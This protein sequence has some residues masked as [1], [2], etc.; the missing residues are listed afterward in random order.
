VNSSILIALTSHLWQSTLFALA[1]GSL[2]LLVRKNSARVRYCMWLAA[3]AKF[4]V[5]FAALTAV[6]ARIPWPLAVHGMGPSMATL[7]SQFGL[8]G[9]RAPAAHADLSG[10]FLPALGVF[11]LLGAIAVVARSFAGWMRI[12]HALRDSTHASLAFVIPV[13]SSAVQLEPAVVGILRPVLLLPR[14]IEQRLTPEQ[15]LTVLAHERCHVVWRDNLAAALHMLVEALFWFHPLIWWLGKRLVDERER[16]CDERVLADGHP[17]ENYAEGIL[18]VCEHYL[19]SRLACAAGVAGANLRQRIEAIMNNRLIERLTGIQKLVIAAAASATIAVPFAA[20]VLTSPHAYAQAGASNTEEPNGSA[21]LWTPNF[22]DTDITMIAQAVSAAT[23]KNFIIDPRVRAQVTLLSAAPM[24]PNAFYQTFLS[25]LEV[26]GFTAKR[27]GLVIKIVPDA[28]AE[29]HGMPP[30]QVG[31]TSDEFITEVVNVKN[32]DAAQLVPILRPMVP[33]YGSLAAYPA[34]NILIISDSSS[35]LNRLIRI[36]R[37][38]DQAGD[39]DLQSA[40]DKLK[41]VGDVTGE[42]GDTNRPPN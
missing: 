25:I 12:H 38:L 20:G 15:V 1:V 10:L 35:N 31:S 22:K 11:W 26:H 17:P 21:Q 9:T 37:G 27:E 32:V 13:R 39:Q 16:A 30:D 40:F 34:A 8:G 23:G 29:Q 5:P 4:L 33:P 3:S 42:A 41:A 14:G 2:T 19:E 7:I 24:S 28:N 36:I 18:R 6:G